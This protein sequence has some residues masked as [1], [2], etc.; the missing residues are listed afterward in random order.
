MK[1][2]LLLLLTIFLLISCEYNPD[3]KSVI[4][5]TNIENSVSSELGLYKYTLSTSSSSTRETYLYSDS[6]YKLNDT[7]IITKK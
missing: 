6:I 3:K 1:K 4:I 7:L 5:I 2:L